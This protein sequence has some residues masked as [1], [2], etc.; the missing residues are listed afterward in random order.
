MSETKRVQ[1][2]KITIITK[3]EWETYCNQWN[4]E[5]NNFL[6][7]YIMMYQ[8]QCPDDYK[9]ASFETNKSIL[10]SRVFFAKSGRSFWFKF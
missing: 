5:M 3:L 8:L 6:S 4:F 7:H 10:I 2:E 9:L 1:V